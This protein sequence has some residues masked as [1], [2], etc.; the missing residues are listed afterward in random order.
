MGVSLRIFLAGAIT[1]STLAAQTSD[2]SLDIYTEHPRLFLGAQRLR[3]LRRERERRTTR[4]LQ[5]ETL[6]TGK[7]LM[8]EPGFANALFYQISGDKQYAG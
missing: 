4:W 8:P 5:I 3:L 6:M 1:V 2:E 7:A